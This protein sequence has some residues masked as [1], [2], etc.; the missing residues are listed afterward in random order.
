MGVFKIITADKEYGMSKKSKDMSK[1]EKVRDL[2]SKISILCSSAVV[3]N[4]EAGLEEIKIIGSPTEKSLLIATI[5]MGYNQEKLGREYEKLD[6]IPF[7]S[8]KKFMVTLHNHKAGG[9]KQ[10]AYDPHIYGQA[11]P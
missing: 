9:H 3:E 6:E 4:P 11:L 5:E 7:N 8:E 2:I 1:I 10:F